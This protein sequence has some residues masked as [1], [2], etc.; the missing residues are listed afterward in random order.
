MRFLSSMETY[1]GVGSACS[2][3]SKEPNKTLTAM[4]VPK[5]IAFGAIRA[6]FGWQSTES[7]IK[8]FLEQI[9]TVI[10]DY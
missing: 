2:A 4:G 7:D 6:S 3:D 1:I 9:Q 8:V 10:K 5:D